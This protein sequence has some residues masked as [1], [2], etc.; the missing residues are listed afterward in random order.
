MGNNE[1]KK[2]YNRDYVKA[3]YD[4]FRVEK[5]EISLSLFGGKCWLCGGTDNFQHYHLHHLEYNPEDSSYRRNSKAQ[6]T[7]QLRLEEAKAHPERFKLL[8]PRCHR[9]VTSVGTY[10]LR[11]WQPVD[12]ELEFENFLWLVLLEMKNRLPDIKIDPDKYTI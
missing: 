9:L 2:Q 6:W 11:R 12:G 5:D 3:N 7:R 10:L 8:C 4:K 1:N